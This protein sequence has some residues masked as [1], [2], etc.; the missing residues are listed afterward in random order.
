MHDDADDDGDDDDGMIMAETERASRAAR[1]PPPS[2]AVQEAAWE[3]TTRIAATL[4]TRHLTRILRAPVTALLK[5]RAGPRDPSQ[6]AGSVRPAAQLSHVFSLQR[7]IDANARES[8]FL[9]YQTV[10]PLEAAQLAAAGMRSNSVRASV[11]HKAKKTQGG[12]QQTTRNSLQDL[13]ASFASQSVAVAVA[14]GVAR[15]AFGRASDPG[16]TV[17]TNLAQFV[18]GVTAP[19]EGPF[20]ATSSTRLLPHALP[21]RIGAHNLMATMRGF[22]RSELDAGTIRSLV[23][24]QVASLKSIC[25]KIC[26]T[27]DGVNVWAAW[28]LLIHMLSDPRLR[29]LVQASPITDHEVSAAY[30]FTN[31]A[32]AEVTR[33]AR[34][35]Q[36]ANQKRA[37]TGATVSH[38][39]T[40]AGPSHSNDEFRRGLRHGVEFARIPSTDVE[41][42]A[43]FVA[44]AA[45][46]GDGDPELASGFKVAC[47]RLGELRGSSAGG[48]AALQAVADKQTLSLKRK[49]PPCSGVVQVSG[50]VLDYWAAAFT[51]EYASILKI[52]ITQSR[53]L[54]NQASVATLTGQAP[55]GFNSERNALL[56]DISTRNAVKSA[57]ALSGLV[58]T[59]P[60]RVPKVVTWRCRNAKGQLKAHTGLVRSSSDA[61][62]VTVHAVRMPPTHLQ[63]ATGHHKVVWSLAIRNATPHD[64]STS[65]V[66][67]IVEGI[68]HLHAIASGKLSLRN[69]RHYAMRVVDKVKQQTKRAACDGA[70]DVTL[71]GVARGFIVVRAKLVVGESQLSAGRAIAESMHAAHETA[72]EAA[73]GVTVSDF[74]SAT[75]TSEAA[76]GV[77]AEPHATPSNNL[78][79]ALEANEQIRTLFKSKN[80]RGDPCRHLCGVATP[81]ELAEAACEEHDRPQTLLPIVDCKVDLL[82]DPTAPLTPLPHRR[83]A[84]LA[85]VAITLTVCG[86]S[87]VRLPELLD[88]FAR[89]QRED[90]VKRTFEIVSLICGGAARASELNDVANS[91][92]AGHVNSSIASAKRIL[93]GDLNLR[94]FCTLFQ[95]Y[96]VGT[97]NVPRSYETTPWSGTYGSGFDIGTSGGIGIRA[98]S[99]TADKR[100]ALIASLHLYTSLYTSTPLNLLA[101][102]TARS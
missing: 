7:P 68:A 11:V 89:E 39:D 10:L 77:A 20:V 102:T 1:S 37:K 13:S 34:I 50:G 88:L 81:Q 85:T 3:E 41:G 47:E 4:E 67:G 55:P 5:T 42:V 52:M 83:D 65:L 63:E 45:E 94:L 36:A 23:P 26:D 2:E 76:L 93:V 72:R 96:R 17:A 32:R 62:N 6:G 100:Y 14:M 84:G 90:Q 38:E 80:H 73:R 91:V 69:N 70:L 25:I 82:D 46:G 56:L 54:A 21:I 19:R 79:L 51:S 49:R 61:S 9:T 31:Y 74:E 44:Q 59:A 101:G 8:S 27:S 29:K 12:G 97:S 98:S 24:Q 18:D 78:A 33:R 30:L 48:Q 15:R 66:P 95:V 87:P 57:E 40:E 99:V 92:S 58:V 75:V 35:D 16:A 71:T 43:E 28:V 22:A 60:E 86:D 53:T 64:A